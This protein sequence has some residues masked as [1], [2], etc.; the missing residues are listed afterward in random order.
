MQFA[1][2]LLN[3]CLGPPLFRHAIFT[4][5]EANTRLSSLGVLDHPQAS[6]KFGNEE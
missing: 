4:T 1:V 3:L 6:P 2:I 5:G